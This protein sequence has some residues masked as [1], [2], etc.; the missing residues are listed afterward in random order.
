MKFAEV[1]IS[2]AAYLE[3]DGSPMIEA[4]VHRNHRDDQGVWHQTLGIR[5]TE[6]PDAVKLLDYA[7]RLLG[8][9]GIKPPEPSTLPP[10]PDAIRH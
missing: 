3:P 1:N 2:F 7:R 4:R 9:L 6:C 5:E 8:S 10:S